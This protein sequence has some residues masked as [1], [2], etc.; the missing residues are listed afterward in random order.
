MLHVASVCTP[1][2][3][4][5][6]VVMSCCAKFETSQPFEQ[7]PTFLKFLKHSVAMLDPFAQLFQQSWGHARALHV[8]S[9]E[10]TMQ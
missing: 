3:I 6:R 1:C 8:V 4:L 2:C 5:L 7:I 9:L 10:T